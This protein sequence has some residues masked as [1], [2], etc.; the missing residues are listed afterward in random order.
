MNKESE[1]VQDCYLSLQSLGTGLNN[2]QIETSDEE[3]H[4]VFREGALKTKSMAD[5]LGKR[6][7]KLKLEGN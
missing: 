6:V 2:L 3:A 5:E 7:Q 1:Y 4:D